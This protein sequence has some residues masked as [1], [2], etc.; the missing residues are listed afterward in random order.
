VLWSLVAV[1]VGLVI[2]IAASDRLVASA[3]RVS[4]ALGVS[5]VLIGA[6]V[7]GLGTSL[8]ELLVSGLA[9]GGGELDI[10]MANV[11]GSNIANVTLVLGAAAL[12]RPIVTRVAVLKRE[13]VLMLAAVV[14]LAAVLYDGVV[15]RIEGFGLVAGMIVALVL[16][17]MWS[18]D[19]GP[20]DLVAADEVEEF[21]DGESPLAVEVVVGLVS[22]A[23]TIFGANLLLNGALDV[24]EELGLSATFLG[25]MLGIGTSLPELATAIAAARRSAPDLVV[26]NVLGSNLFNS[27]AVAGI[28][29]ITGPATLVDLGPP[30]LWFMVGAVAA[31]G[32]FTRTGRLNRAEATV[33]LATFFVFL[34]FTF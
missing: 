32:V 11:V 8:P 16:L 29:A 7:V 34:G 20:S 26:G 6:L 22:L 9:A 15:S 31:A 4:Q 30:A 1:G 25:V 13:G 14:A 3:V 12:L 27:L 33:L 28:A 10:A 18:R 19:H 17:I 5:A 2:L 23:A 21:A 24:G